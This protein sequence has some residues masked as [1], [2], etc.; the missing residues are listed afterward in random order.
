[1]NADRM[2]LSGGSLSLPHH[3]FAFRF[4][5]S[6]RF[7]AKTRALT[8]H[9]LNVYVVLCFFVSEHTGFCCLILFVAVSFTI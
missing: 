1:M 4:S 5:N 3:I 7:S 8:A 2:I 9:I 6:V